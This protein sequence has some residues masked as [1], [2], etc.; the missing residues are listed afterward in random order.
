MRACA[1]ACGGAR[2]QSHIRTLADPSMQVSTGA[3]AGPRPQ[4]FLTCSFISVSTDHRWSA[5]RAAASGTEH[6]I[7]T[8][9]ISPD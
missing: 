2:A 1:R 4:S 7:V 6:T 9:L 3:P 8:G 5:P